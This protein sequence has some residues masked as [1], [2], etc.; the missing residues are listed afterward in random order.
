MFRLNYAG[1]ITVAIAR[2]C[3]PLISRTVPVFAA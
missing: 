1:V 2:S 3:M